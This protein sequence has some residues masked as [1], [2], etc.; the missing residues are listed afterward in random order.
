MIGGFERP[1]GMNTAS[2]MDGGQVGGQPLLSMGF[3]DGGMMGQP[4]GQ[5]GMMGAPGGANGQPDPAQMETQVN[6]LLRDP[7]VR[8][9][10]VARA[11]QLMQSGQ[12]TP[13]EVQTMG[14]I[15][16]A[17]M[18]N[19]ALYPQLRAFALQ[20][21]MSSL[22]P[23]YD[24]TAIMKILA[25]TRALSGDGG[26]QAPG[27]EGGMEGGMGGPPGM[28]MEGGE[29]PPGQ[30]PGMDQ[31]MMSPP[32]GMRDGGMLHGPG[33]G[34][35]DSIGTVNSSTGQPVK[36]A[37]G[38]YVIPAHVVKAKGREFFDNLLRRY[39]DV[40]KGQE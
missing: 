11:Q 7:N 30:V 27:M 40:P 31:A 29:T 36:V 33:T 39:V 34:R 12:L 4:G 3:A 10:I 18:Y 15:A 2:Y 20:Q 35:S 13:Q 37:N 5:P 25:V 16:Q 17:A 28:G 24:P 26:Q 38:E 9:Q 6:Q 23:S 8:N 21:G 14:Q 1:A 19:P 32:A 22:P